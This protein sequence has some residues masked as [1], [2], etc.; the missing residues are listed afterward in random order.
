MKVHVAAEDVQT[1]TADS[2]GRITLGSEFSD[3]T[4]EVAVLDVV[5]SDD[6]E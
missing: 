6:E 3:E 1:V 2:R 5:E 4:V